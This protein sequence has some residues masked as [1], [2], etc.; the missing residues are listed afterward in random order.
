MKFKGELKFQLI[1]ILLKLMEKSY[2]Q[3]EIINNYE[4]LDIIGQGGFSEVY[5]VKSL[6][7]DIIFAAKVFK[8]N[9]NNI[10]NSF[11][12]EINILMK[13]D[14]P[15]IIRIYDFFIYKNSL[16][17][18]L[19]YCSKN[20]LFIEIQLNN[21]FNEINFLNF[22][23][24]ISDALSLIHKNG[25]AHNDIKPQNILINDYGKPKLS[26]FGLSNLDIIENEKIIKG[27]TF[28]LAPEIILKSCLNHL[29]ADI[30]SLGI[31]FYY[32]LFGIFP[33]NNNNNNIFLKNYKFQTPFFPDS[34]N[35]KIKNLLKSMLLFNPN[36]RIDIITVKKLLFQIKEEK[37]KKNR[38]D[39]LFYLNTKSPIKSYSSPFFK[40]TFK[41]IKKKTKIVLI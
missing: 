6:K 15:N 17:I 2:F 5:K 14:H 21:V 25:I 10:F 27:T 1:D 8:H 7:Y 12:S 23:Y 35:L 39:F 28:F 3:G 13:L 18:I 34:M 16:I 36:D 31:T 41:K 20:N 19:E 40:L 29:K 30:W 11:V 22:S 33:F 32:M 24:Q 4:F 38:N 37:F 9:I 26:D